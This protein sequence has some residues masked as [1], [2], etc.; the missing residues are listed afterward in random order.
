MAE[1]AYAQE[2]ELFDDAGVHRELRR[3][4]HFEIVLADDGSLDELGHGAMGRTYRAVDTI[5]QSPVALK[6]IGENV[7]DSPAVRRRF[8]A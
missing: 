8:F 7:A 2:E 3:Y 1:L 4:S 6:V 5:L